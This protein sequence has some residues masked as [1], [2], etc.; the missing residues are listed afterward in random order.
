VEIA[1]AQEFI[2]GAMDLVRAGF[3]NYVRDGATG[4]SKF[5]FEVTGRDIHRLN[6]FDGW[7]IDL[8]QTGT[9]VIVDAFH[10]IVVAHSHLAVDFRLQRARGVEELRV[11]ERSARGAGNQVQQILEIAIRA[12]GQV[13]RLHGF[14]LGSGIGAVG[15]QRWRR[16][17][18][19]DGFGDIARLHLN[20]DTPTGIDDQIDLRPRFLF[21]AFRFHGYRVFAGRQIGNGIVTALVRLCRATDARIGF[22]DRYRRIRNGSSRSVGNGSQQRCIHCLSEY[23]P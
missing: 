12:Y 5:R 10:L 19:F 23:C 7:D 14:D 16:G 6:R 1:V 13:R 15:L 8:Q 4:T 21:E 11:L 9:L 2:R 20:V 3:Q 17:R 22:R 18:N